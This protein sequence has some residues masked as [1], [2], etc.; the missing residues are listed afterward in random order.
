MTSFYKAGHLDRALS[1]EVPV[2][3]RLFAICSKIEARVVDNAPGI[4]QDDR[5][6]L[7]GALEACTRYR[8]ILRNQA[9]G[10]PTSTAKSSEAWQR[11]DELNLFDYAEEPTPGETPGFL[12]MISIT[13]NLLHAIIAVIDYMHEFNPGRHNPTKAERARKEIPPDVTLGAKANIEFLNFFIALNERLELSRL[14][15]FEI[16]NLLFNKRSLSLAKELELVGNWQFPAGVWAGVKGYWHLKDTQPDFTLKT[17]QDVNED[18]SW[19]V[20]LV[21]EKREGDRL[22]ELRLYQIKGRS[23]EG[24]DVFDLSNQDDMIRLRQRM[25]SLPAHDREIHQAELDS[26]IEYAGRR[27]RQ[28]AKSGNPDC[29][30]TPFWVEAFADFKNE[31]L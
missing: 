30:V 20:D 21:G 10:K 19:G 3:K 4:G 5:Q 26:I 15:Q 22:V 9:D 7:V 13:R 8:N 25:E 6:Y 12:K 31:A 18:V 28:E 24:V 2:F 17:P 14:E 23:R 29:R 27:K 16:F 11:L 1:A